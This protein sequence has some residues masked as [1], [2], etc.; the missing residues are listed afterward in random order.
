MF[1]RFGAGILIAVLLAAVCMPSAGLITSGPQSF[2]Y[3][4]MGPRLSS[5]FGFRE[6]PV[7]NVKKHHHGVDLA[8]PDGAVIR[9]I[10]S[11][12][13]VFADSYGSYGKLIVV[14][15]ENGMTS[16]Y[17]HCES[18]KVG[19]G[20]AVKAGQIIGTVGHT[21]RVTGAHLHFEIRKNGEPQ[22]PEQFLPNLQIQ[23][24]G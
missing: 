5:K 23:A 24:Q 6:H 12:R 3:P 14:E 22:N 9:S 8:A 13:V 16:H 21:G 17:G 2:V 10:S 7:L 15:H 19:P 18:I 11:G 1:A 20:K 4:V